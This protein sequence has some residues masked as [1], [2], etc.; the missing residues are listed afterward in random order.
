MVRTKRR[1]SEPIGPF[2]TLL[3]QQRIRAG[4]TTKGLRRRI[5]EV[6]RSAPSETLLSYWHRGERMPRL[7]H[8]V[9]L[10]RAL[11]WSPS[12][13]LAAYDA[14]AE[15]W[16]GPARQVLTLARRFGWTDLARLDAYDVAAHAENQ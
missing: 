16:D 12:E 7:D 13:R 15:Q 11:G 4:L 9:A 1:P 8:V 14:H 2:G 10:S 3:H 5:V 6:A